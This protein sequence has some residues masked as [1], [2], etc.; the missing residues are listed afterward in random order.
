MAITTPE[1]KDAREARFDITPGSWGAGG[2][3]PAG[4][5]KPGTERGTG[6]TPARPVYQ[7]GSP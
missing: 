6:F 3:K 7:H 4:S 1:V 5:A 2:S